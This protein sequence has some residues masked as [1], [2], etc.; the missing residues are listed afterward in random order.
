MPLTPTGLI[1]DFYSHFILR[2]AYCR[3]EDLR[4]WFLSNELELFK[5]RFVNN[6]P[7]DRGTWLRSHGLKYEAITRD[8]YDEVK[9]ELAQTLSSR[10]DL[11]A[12]QID[13]AEHY[14]VPRINYIYRYRYRYI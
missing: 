7:D 4:R 13:R 12:G 6:A 2:L 14:K 3:S 10:R 5:W 11:D 1:K 8:E 9:E